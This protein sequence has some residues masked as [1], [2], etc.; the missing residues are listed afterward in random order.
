MREKVRLAAKVLLGKKRRSA[1]AQ[2]I[3]D[4]CFLCSQLLRIV[5]M[6]FLEQG[7]EQG[8]SK[9]GSGVV[10]VPVRIPRLGELDDEPLGNR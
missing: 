9:C 5:Q 6:C 3:F 7:S 8:G 4:K 2:I 10:F 1:N